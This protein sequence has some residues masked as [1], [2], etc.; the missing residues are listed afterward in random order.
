MVIFL[1]WSSSHCLWVNLVP[2]WFSLPFLFTSW[3]HLLPL[4]YSYDVHL[5]HCSFYFCLNFHLCWVSFPMCFF[6]ICS[7]FIP[8]SPIVCNENQIMNHTIHIRYGDSCNY[9][10]YKTIHQMICI[11][12]GEF[13]NYGIKDQGIS[14]NGVNC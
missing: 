12:G 2:G 5:L 6:L 7:I 13:C 8:L 14:M 10:G 1:P 11:A 3:F 4:H 9:S